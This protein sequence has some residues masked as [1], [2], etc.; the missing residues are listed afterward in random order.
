MARLKSANNAQTTLSAAITST[1]TSFTVADA[2]LF[3]AAPFKITVDAEIMEVGVI[4]TSTKTFS[5]VLRGQEGSV[6]AAHNSGA[7]VEN[8]FTAGSY[9]ELLDATA[10]Q[11]HIDADNPHG[12]TAADIGAVTTE[13]ATTIA[14]TEAAN[15]KKDGTKALVVEVRTSDPASPAIGQMWLRSDL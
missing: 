1:T 10:L 4:N 11:A 3:P 6:A 12:I 13:D 5:S 9:D 15:I 8:R 2:S 7:S 14:Q